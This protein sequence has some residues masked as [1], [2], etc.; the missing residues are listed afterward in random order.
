MERFTKLFFAAIFLL[1]ISSCD[2]KSCTKVVC[3]SYQTCFQG[4]CMCQDGYQGPNCDSLSSI[5]YTGNWNVSENCGG[6]ASNFSGYQ[7]YISPIGSPA[8]YIN[9]S[10]LLNL[11]NP[12]TAQIYNNTPGSEGMSIFIPAQNVG[13]ISISNSYGTYST[14]TGNAVLTI[15]LNYTYNSI[16]YQCQET[17]YK[18]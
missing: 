5:Q 11:G 16:N 12:C 3:A 13:G 18:F 10:N 1:A 9:I 17:M 2:K 14:A 7:V 15:V 6:G 8:N 4:Q